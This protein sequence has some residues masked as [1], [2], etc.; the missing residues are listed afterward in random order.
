MRGFSFPLRGQKPVSSV[1]HPYRN[2]SFVPGLT[3]DPGPSPFVPH[4]LCRTNPRWTR[5]G[6]SESTRRTSVT[7]SLVFQH[8]RRSTVVSVS[9]IRLGVVRPESPVLLLSWV[10]ALP[11]SGHSLEVHF[12][13]P[14]HSPPVF[15]R[16]HLVPPPTTPEW[17]PLTAPPRLQ[18]GGPPC[19]PVA[20][21]RT[22]TSFPRGGPRPN[23][24]TPH[25]VSE[26]PRTGGPRG[27]SHH[28]P[29]LRSLGSVGV[30]S[31]V[32][33]GRGGNKN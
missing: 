2:D 19:E 1:P 3:P 26:G 16:C 18:T 27:P 31:G 13:A 6:S 30:G 25:T 32:Q 21:R 5:P 7:V 12:R 10:L 17:G 11:S 33:D 4:N 24:S 14:N 29:P 9:G 28:G 8:C 20:T 15:D 22:T 23:P